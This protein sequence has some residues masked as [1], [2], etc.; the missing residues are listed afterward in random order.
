MRST[1]HVA[2]ISGRV[3]R[4]GSLEDNAEVLSHSSMHLL[5]QI[6]QAVSVMQVTEAARKHSGTA[7][8]KVQDAKDYAS[9]TARA[10]SDYVKDTQQQGESA[11]QKVKDRVTETVDKVSAARQPLSPYPVNLC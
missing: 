9:D 8:Q 1:L 2:T 7:S 3:R 10:G 5:R 6:T 4:V 11:W